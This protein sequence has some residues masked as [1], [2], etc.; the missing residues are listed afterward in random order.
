MGAM[1]KLRH[2]A[3][4][5][6]L[7]GCL[8][9]F[10]SAG[11]GG[12]GS[13]SIDSNAH[14]AA[15]LFSRTASQTLARNFSSP[16]ISYLFYDAR[17]DRFIAAKWSESDQPV[18]IGSLAKP[19][20]ALAYAESHDYRFPEHVCSGGNSCWLTKGH[21]ALGIVEAISFSCNSYFTELASNIEGSQ[22][23]AVARRFGLKGP[24]GNASPEAMAGRFGVWRESPERLVRAYAMLL[25]RR[26]QP[27]IGNIVDGMAASARVGTAAGLARQG[28]HQNYLAKTGTALC[29]HAEHAPGD[30]FAIVAWPSHLPRYLLLV[31]QHSVPG[32]QAA[33]LA[34]RMLRALEP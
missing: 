19:F 24:G 5:G 22:V 23:T 6:I 31:R 16:N 21:G 26:S 30:G 20:T 33:V 7:T 28:L 29:T 15:A 9:A 17:D 2:I 4:V 27:A 18:A 14:D 1:N 12:A 8:M 11:S 3:A 25:G 13:E 10:A 34:G 32:A